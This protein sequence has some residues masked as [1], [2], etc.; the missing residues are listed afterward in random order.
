MTESSN[1]NLDTLT[2]SAAER[3]DDIIT[4][5]ETLRTKLRSKQ[6]DPRAGLRGELPG[7]LILDIYALKQDHYLACVYHLDLLFPS[8]LCNRAILRCVDALLLKHD[9]QTALWSIEAWNIHMANSQFSLL[10]RRFTPD[11]LKNS[12][13]ST[14]LML[15][16]LAH[17][18]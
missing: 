9:S 11:W 14:P 13:S 1:F 8:I 16:D 5:A 7:N 18:A 2:K 4:A 3:L 15:L 6:I 17:V 12:P 10:C